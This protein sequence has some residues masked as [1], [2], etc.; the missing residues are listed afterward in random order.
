MEERR[1]MSSSGVISAITDNRGQTVAFEIGSNGQVYEF[2]PAVSSGWFPL[3]NYNPTG[4]RQVSAG[5]DA[6]GRAICYA[7]HNGDNYVW[8]MDN[9]ST[10]GFTTEGFQLGFTASQISASRN[11]ECFGIHNQWGTSYVIQYHADA[12]HGNGWWYTPWNGPWG[13]LVQISAGVDRYGGDEVYLLNGNQQVYRLDNGTYWVLPMRATQISA[14]IGS[15]WTDTDLFYIDTTVNQE[16]FHYDGSSS[17]AIALYV[18]QISAGLDQYGNEVLYSIDMYYHWV[19]R[20]DL[21]GNLNGVG[22]GGSVSQI[23]AAGNDMVFGVAS[24]DNSVWV[25]D[26]NWS[27]AYYWVETYNYGS[28]GWHPLNSTTASPYNSPLAA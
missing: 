4:F 15:N 3:V 23:S 28:G 21:S 16:A 26:R 8:E 10:H 17:Q 25:Y 14:G 27:W 24:W 18:A 5:L 20:H 19:N 6:Y 7:I 11:N 2:N 12:N 1:L 9:Y 22:V 13:S